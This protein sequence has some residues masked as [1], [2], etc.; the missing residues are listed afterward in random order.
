MSEQ[1]VDSLVRAIEAGELSDDDFV[2]LPP[3]VQRTVTERLEARNG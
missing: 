2:A 1:Y 3:D